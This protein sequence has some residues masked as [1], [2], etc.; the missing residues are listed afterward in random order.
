M[1]KYEKLPQQIKNLIESYYY[2]FDEKLKNTTVIVWLI[3]ILI[4]IVWIIFWSD[5]YSELLTKSMKTN[6]LE[7][8]VD[9]DWESPRNLFTTNGNI[10]E[11]WW[12]K[13]N[14]VISEM[15]K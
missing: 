10:I 5:N 9:Y 1:Y 12:V 3:G 14:V 8:Q 6:V 15:E 4:L 11:I 2:F 7:S 13:Y